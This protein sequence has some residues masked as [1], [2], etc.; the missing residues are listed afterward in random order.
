MTEHDVIQ[1]LFIIEYLFME[2]DALKPTRSLKRVSMLS[3][4]YLLLNDLY[5]L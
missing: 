1:L 3:N 5:S 2:Q 4:T